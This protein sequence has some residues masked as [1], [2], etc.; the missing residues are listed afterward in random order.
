[1]I[2]RIGKRKFYGKVFGIIL[3]LFALSFVAAGDSWAGVSAFANGTP[4][5]VMPLGDSITLGKYSGHDPVPGVDEPE[6]DIGYR[7]DLWDLL[8]AAGYNVDFVGTESNGSA[9]PFSDPEHEGHNG[10]TDSQIAD[11]IYNEPGG[12][13]WLIS[14]TPDVILLHIGTN[15]LSINP[16]DVEMVLD[17]INEY[18][19][20]TAS[21]VNVIV[22]RI[23]DWVPNNPSVRIFNN[24]VETMV[25][26]RLDYGTELFLV[27]MESQAGMDYS[28]GVDMID[29]LHPLASGYTKMAQCWKEAFDVI[30]GTPSANNLPVFDSP[31]GNQ[32]NLEGETIIPP[33]DMGATD[34]DGGDTLTYSALNLP[35]G[36]TINSETGAIFGTISS[37]ASSGSPYY[38]AISVSDGNPCGSTRHVFYW[39]VNEYN[40]PPE[41]QN[42]GLNRV[43]DEGDFVQIDIDATDPNDTNLDYSATNLPPGI[44]INSNNG[45]I[46]GVIS[47]TASEQAQF[48]NFQVEVKVADDGNPSLEDTV[49][50]TW[51]VNDV[52]TDA[53]VVNNPG[54]QRNK[55]GEDISLQIIASDPEGEDLDFVAENLPGNLV[56][57][58]NTGEISGQIQEWAALASPYD[59]TVTVTDESAN[60]TAID[61]TWIVSKEDIFLPLVL[62]K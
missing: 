13:N 16:S 32:T 40:Q 51:T 28:T 17:E 19:V 46:S 45:L 36:L 50:F 1:M 53:P 12:E 21:T 14:Q 58:L 5:R 3:L 22:A 35:D 7:K 11:N 42:T 39:T 25:K 30:Y 33:K 41:I 20:A 27:E 44:N 60:S 23:I 10:W 8:Q 59:I 4:I 48:P 57:N 34:I 31:L 43:D 26:N 9:Y 54:D 61:F 6:D 18:E 24:N 47:Y 37:S 49:N 56:I 55:T 38:V 29:D 52:A 62:K 15:N 2:N